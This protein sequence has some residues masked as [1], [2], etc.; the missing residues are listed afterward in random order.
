MRSRIALALAPLLWLA[1]AFAPSFARADNPTDAE[2]TRLAQRVSAAGADPRGVV[3]LLELWD[4]WDRSTPRKLV[5]ELTKLSKDQRLSSD[6][7]VLVETMLA[8]ARLRLGDPNA[9]TQR[10][11]ELGYVTKFRVIGP[12]D[13]EGKAGFDKPMPVEEKRMEAPDLQATYPGRE[14]PV[15]WRDLPEVTR[16]GF[17]PFGALMR[18]IENVCGFAE[19]FVKSEKARPL[20]LWWCGEGVLEWGRGG[21]RSGLP[22]SE[23]RP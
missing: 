23:S 20:T 4:N 11:D 16:N 17:V 21:R 22:R 8:Q 7:R 14:R 18:P 19:T 15:A 12:F 10:F 3:P 9:V 2:N 13:N 6:R 5:S 1:P